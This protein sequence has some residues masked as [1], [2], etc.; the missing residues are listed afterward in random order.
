[1]SLNISHNIFLPRISRLEFHNLQMD[2]AM[3]FCTNESWNSISHPTK[4]FSEFAM[5][6]CFGFLQVCQYWLTKC[7]ILKVRCSNN[8]FLIR[9][10]MW[11]T[12][13][14]SRLAKCVL[15]NTTW[16]GAIFISCT[17]ILS[18]SYS[19]LSFLI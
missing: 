1:M 13:L 8:Q 14:K 12:K 7:W 19:F 17:K 16:L 10:G 5:N 9:L 11:W 3:P 2:F 6:F 4:V 18:Q 15:N